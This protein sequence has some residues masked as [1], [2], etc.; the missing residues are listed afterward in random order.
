MIKSLFK[1][2]PLVFGKKVMKLLNKLLIVFMAVL[3]CSLATA[4]DD[5]VSPK[6]KILVHKV[7]ADGTYTPL[8]GIRL[9]QG[10]IALLPSAP[11][12]PVKG[13][14]IELKALFR[15][16]NMAILDDD[17]KS[18]VP[19]TVANFKISLEYELG[20]SDVEID[21]WVSDLT[22]VPMDVLKILKGDGDIQNKESD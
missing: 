21:Y 5:E 19:K 15:K 11:R 13:E 14:F 6:I 12:D 2:R 9:K 7:A 18:V 20:K 10:K 16:M 3:G 1:T 4:S 17:M 22:V 8:H